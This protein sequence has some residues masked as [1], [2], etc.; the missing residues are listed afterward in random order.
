MPYIYK[1]LKF[2]IQHKLNN[3]VVRL[4]L[5]SCVD[6]M[7]ILIMRICNTVLIHAKAR[8]SLSH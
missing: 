3:R 8:T 5:K 4:F 6:Y 7:R 2:L 1:Y